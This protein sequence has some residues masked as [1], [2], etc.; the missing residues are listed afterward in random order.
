MV[1]Y[2][3]IVF[4]VVSDRTICD[5][6]WVLECSISN[7]SWD[8]CRVGSFEHA[9][10]VSSHHHWTIDSVNSDYTSMADEFV[11]YSRYIHG[12]ILGSACAVLETKAIAIEAY[13]RSGILSSQDLHLLVYVFSSLTVSHSCLNWEPSECLSCVLVSS[14]SLPV[15]TLQN[16][17]L[18]SNLLLI[19]LAGC[20]Q[21]NIVPQ[22]IEKI[23]YRKCAGILSFR[24]WED[25]FLSGPP[26]RA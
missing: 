25:F 13:E 18:S 12:L 15:P 3:R 16:P 22:G 6:A 26:I 24:I 5:L 21:L 23:H 20:C 19:I 10:L 14:R 9:P 7:R 1:K 4:L 8:G 11:F 17:Y 2:S